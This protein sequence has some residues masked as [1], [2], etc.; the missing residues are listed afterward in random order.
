MTDG[1]FDSV[2]FRV[3]QEQ[4]ASMIKEGLHKELAKYMRVMYDAFMAVGFDK[5]QALELTKMMCNPRRN[6]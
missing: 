3:A 4:F 5:G 1:R 6:P 2:Q